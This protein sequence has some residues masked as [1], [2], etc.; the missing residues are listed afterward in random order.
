[1]ESFLGR[2]FAKEKGPDRIAGLA[3]KS[4]ERDLEVQITIQNGQPL[5]SPP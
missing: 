5:A 1:V 4:I 3:A 2:A